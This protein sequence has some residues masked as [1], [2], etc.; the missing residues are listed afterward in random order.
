MVFE[1]YLQLVTDYSKA[2][3]MS[4]QPVN[5]EDRYRMLASGTS[6]GSVRIDLLD[7]EKVDGRRTT[8]ISKF[9]FSAF[10]QF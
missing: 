1:W 10:V 3:I 4:Y 8:V 9:Q 2:V 5:A 7:F 6:Q